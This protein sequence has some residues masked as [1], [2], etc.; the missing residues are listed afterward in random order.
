[1]DYNHI[2]DVRTNGVSVGGVSGITALDYTWS[3]VDSD[4][5]LAV[6][7]AQNLAPGGTPEAWLAEHGLAIGE[8]GSD[9]DGDGMKASDEY[10]AGTDPSDPMSVLKITGA[11]LSGDVGFTLQWPSV[12]GRTYD[13]E[14]GT[15]LLDAVPFQ[16]LLTDIKATPSTN[17]CLV[18]AP[19]SGQHFFRLKV[20]IAQ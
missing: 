3:S 19:P 15:N 1:M 14:C 11:D 16:P 6:D 7:F 2:G 12:A 17:S 13:V 18:S 9:K 10:V 20:N 4:S 5:V 8:E